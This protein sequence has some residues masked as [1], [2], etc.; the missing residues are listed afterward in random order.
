MKPLCE[1]HNCSLVGPLHTHN[2]E[3][4]EFLGTSIVQFLSRRF[5][6]GLIGEWTLGFKSEIGSG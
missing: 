2:I 1:P 3:L 5:S 6:E 4:S